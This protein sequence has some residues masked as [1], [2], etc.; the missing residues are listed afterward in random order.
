MKFKYWALGLL[1]CGGL[2]ACSNNDDITDEGGKTDGGNATTSYLAVNILNTGSTGTRADDYD[3][4]TDE[5]NDIANLRFYLFDEDGNAYTLP[6]SKSYVTATYNEPQTSSGNVEE[7]GTAMLQIQGTPASIVAVANAPTGLADT[8]SLSELQA[9]CAT[10]YKDG[11]GKFIMSNSVYLDGSNNEVCAVSV[12]GHIASTQEA[13]KQNPVD[14][15]IERVAAKVGVSC[16]QSAEDYKNIDGADCFKVADG[17]YAKVCGWTLLSC[18]TKSFLV[19]NIDKSWK[20]TPGEIPGFDW[21]SASDHRSFWAKMPTDG[22][23]Y[24]E[25]FVLNG[26]SNSE[27]SVYTLEN[28]SG[29]NNTILFVKAQLVDEEGTAVSRYVYLGN[30]YGSEDDVM[31]AIIPMFF[32]SEGEYYVKTSAGEGDENYSTLRLQDLKFV[33]GTSLGDDE[34]SYRVYPQLKT[35]FTNVA[36]G[37][38]LKLYTKNGDDY[39]PVSSL[40]D[41]N[42]KLKGY[43]AQIWTEGWCYYTTPI[44]HTGGIAGVV[45]NH[46]YK[47]TVNGITG[48]GT[49]VYDPTEDIHYPTIPVDDNSYVS[50]TINILAWKIVESSVILGQ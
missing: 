40:D 25:S 22:V 1:A 28:T 35:P 17:V 5:E 32:A 24:H 11:N 44:N 6:S 34:N 37:E 8:Y 39:T 7:K 19:K 48:F 49:P 41:V 14:I 18:P 29:D 2:M 42:N 15:Y 46:V 10:D 47:V 16:N 12:S 45:R 13:A 26:V 50:T 30:N 43:S 4:G 27:N 33:T 3:P 9:E 20:S 31:K 23:D 38:D 21:N 36:E